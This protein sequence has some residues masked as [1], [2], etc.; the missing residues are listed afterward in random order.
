METPKKILKNKKNIH[1]NVKQSTFRNIYNY[2][3]VYSYL[4]RAE[5]PG[6]LLH[7]HC[8]QE[9]LFQMPLK[10]GIFRV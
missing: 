4:T 8:M 9:D 2:I 7:S 1:Y 10:R 3:N 6:H 5:T